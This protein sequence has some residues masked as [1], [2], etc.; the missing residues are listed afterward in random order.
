MYFTLFLYCGT[1][2]ECYIKINSVISF[3]EEFMDG[4][5]VLLCILVCIAAYY[6]FKINYIEIDSSEKV[7]MT[8]K[9]AVETIIFLWFWV[10]ILVTMSILIFVEDKSIIEGVSSFVLPCYFAYGNTIKTAVT[11]KGITTVDILGRRCR[12][13]LEWDMIERY[14][15]TEE[16][17]VIFYYRSKQDKLIH[18][19]IEVNKNQIEKIEEVVSKY[20]KN[21]VVQVH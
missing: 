21:E 13:Q 6:K 8:I 19:S 7:E 10:G 12:Q 4:I 17:K 1:N 20:L 11:S 2:G 14:E 5:F 15:I 16:N 9:I 3:K 18:L